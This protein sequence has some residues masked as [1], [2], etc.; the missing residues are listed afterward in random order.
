MTTPARMSITSATV[1]DNTASS[2]VT[3]GSIDGNVCGNSNHNNDNGD[4]AGNGVTGNLLVGG[5]AI[6]NNGMLEVNTVYADRE[7]AQEHDQ[8]RQR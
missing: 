5:G 2:S 1:S 6:A 7:L 4:G 8:Q 3:N